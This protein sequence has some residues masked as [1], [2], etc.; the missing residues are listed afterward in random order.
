MDEDDDECT[1]VPSHQ[2]NVDSESIS[3]IS[4]IVGNQDE[5]ITDTQQSTIPVTQ[6]V[7]LTR[8]IQEDVF[9]SR[10]INEHTIRAYF[11]RQLYDSTNASTLSTLSSS[12][13][14]T[15]MDVINLQAIQDPLILLKVGL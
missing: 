9:H 3:R 14:S 8:T 11:P 7:Q 15:G 12:R 6:N 1:I 10:I 13:F 4:N 2:V 5:N